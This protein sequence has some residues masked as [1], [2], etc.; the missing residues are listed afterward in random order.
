[1]RDIVTNRTT[2]FF[3]G[4]ARVKPYEIDLQDGESSQ[5]VFLDIE[6]GSI[7]HEQVPA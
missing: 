2:C 1:L 4:N 5:R 3:C 7:K 6:S